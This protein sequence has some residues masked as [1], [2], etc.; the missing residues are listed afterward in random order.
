MSPRPPATSGLLV[1]IGLLLVA[2]NQRTGLA[3]LPP[4]AAEIEADTG[5]DPAGIGL[6]STLM[7]V[8]MGLLAPLVPKAARGL[9]SDRT[10]MAGLLSIALGSVVRLLDPPVLTLSIGSVLIGAGITSLGTLLPGVLATRYP[11][12]TGTLTGWTTLALAGGATLAAAAAVPLSDLGGWRVS[13][14]AWA[15]PALMGIALWLPQATPRSVESSPPAP[16]PMRSR[17]AWQVVIYT[18]LGTIGFFS[19]L[20]WIAPTYGQAG[21]TAEIA[22]LYLASLTLGNMAGAFLGPWLAER[23]RDRRP[24]LVGAILVGVIGIL[25][26]GWAGTQDLG[27]ASSVLLT[28][29][30]LPPAVAGIGL[31][32]AFGVSLLMLADVAAHPVASRG[33]AA[34]TFLVAFLVAAP[35]PA[36]L[37]WLAD[38]TGGY[39]TGWLVTAALVSCAVLATRALGPAA[40]KSVG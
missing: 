12:R 25:G 31:G 11:D 29:T 39:L 20:A 15:I 21:V 28:L 5:L 18:T 14:A 10:L 34:M 26:V 36:I 33:L 9:G 8:T 24:V 32:A 19:S 17:T 38:R 23:V 35:F 6:Q 3:G 40:Q 2:S 16:M 4:L 30:Y 1:T 7:I 13:L 37:G 27:S 22:G